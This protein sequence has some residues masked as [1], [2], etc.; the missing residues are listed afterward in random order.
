MPSDPSHDSLLELLGAVESLVGAEGVDAALHAAVEAACRVTGSRRGMA[1]LYDG[2]AVTSDAWYDAAA[3]WTKA[4]LRWELDQ[5]APGRVCLSATPLVCND[6]PSSTSSLAEA[7][8]VLGLDSFAC[9]PLP[10]PDGSAMGFIEVGNRDADYSATDIRLL[11]V[12]ARITAA[13]LQTLARRGRR[14]VEEQAAHADIAERL[15]Q[16]L[17]PEEPPRLPGL[18]VAF[19]YRSASAGVLSGGDFVDY[20]SRSPDTLA[21]AIG[22]VA[23][24]GVEAMATTFVTKYIL[25]AA[26]HGGQLSWPTRPGE[27]LQELRTGLLEQP[28]F[29]AE[30]ER[31]VTVLFG[32]ISTRRGSLQLASAGHPTPFIIRESAVE[33]PLLLTEAAIGVELGAALT[34]YPTETVDLE[35]GDIV[36]LFTDGITEL[37]NAEGD[38]FE[39]EMA[40]LLAGRHDTPAADIVAHLA[41]A[42]AAFSARP[43]AD[44]LALLCIR[45]TVDRAVD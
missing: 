5:G 32:L 35:R 23:G 1:G 19:L 13:R 25:R 42:G 41:T 39:D 6:L 40:G 36:V 4:R 7:T 34:P 30:T 33:R 24:K 45:L 22:D 31:F 16:R 28:D 2:E 3:G 18:D 37:R 17:L 9:A 44:D 38:F 11:S 8:E 43:P 29:G 20:Y 21:F 14:L 12:L 15:Q 10:A 27:A 26:V